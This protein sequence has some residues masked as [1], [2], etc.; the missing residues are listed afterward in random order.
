MRV[1]CRGPRSCRACGTPYRIPASLRLPVEGPIR[2]YFAAIKWLGEVVRDPSLCKP[3]APVLQQH[4]QRRRELP[5]YLTAGAAGGTASVGPARDRDRLE[6]TPPFREGLEERDPLRA[7][8]Q[9][10]RAL[11]GTARGHG[12]IVAQE[13]GPHPELGRWRHR[14]LHRRP[15][16]G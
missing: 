2:V 7:D 15:R 13:R 6:A 8:P 4:F 10:R 1:V 14:H 11:D 9:V 5:E 3:A 16:P 12:G